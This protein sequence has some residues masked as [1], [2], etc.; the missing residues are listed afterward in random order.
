MADKTKG[1]GGVRDE[2]LMAINESFRDALYLNEDAKWCA[3][4]MKIGKHRELELSDSAAMEMYALVT[5]GKN[6]EVTR[7]NTDGEGYRAN[8]ESYADL[9][10]LFSG[11]FMA[12]VVHSDT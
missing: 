4:L 8:I 9:L 3:D 6:F 7:R 12:E 10:A 2:G 11:D 1:N 5:E